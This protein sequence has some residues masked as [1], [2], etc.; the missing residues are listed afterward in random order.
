MPWRRDLGGPRVQIELAEELRARG[1][2]VEKFS[3]EDAYPGS[4]LPPLLD[5]ILPSFAMKVHRRIL[6]N[7]NYDVIDAHQGNLIRSKTSLGFAGRLVV[8]SAGLHHFYA[9]YL[10]RADPHK[11]SGL[12]NHLGRVT[13]RIGSGIATWAVERSFDAADRVVIHNQTEYDFLTLDPSWA[14]KARIVPAPISRQS[15][16][17]LSSVRQAGVNG[18][19]TPAVGFVGS[20]HPRKGSRDWPRLAHLLS[21]GL[22]EL[23]FHFLGTGVEGTPPGLPPHV[24]WVPHYEPEELPTLLTKVDVGVFPSYLEG[25]GIAVVEQL[26]AGIPVVAYDVPGPRD[27]LHPVDPSL[28]IRPGDIASL[29]ERTIALFLSGS[30]SFPELRSRCVARARELTWDEWAGP[31]LDYYRGTYDDES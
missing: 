22:P 9:R 7:P 26:A 20:W 2:S 31:M 27:I 15:F 24:V 10:W 30:G 25:Y 1:H 3:L 16:S 5:G 23:R 19:H 21:S 14:Q 13:S 6:N 11:S 28:L 29:A 4:Q 17:T 18:N 8:R 12:R